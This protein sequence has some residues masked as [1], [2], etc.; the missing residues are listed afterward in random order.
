MQIKTFVT[1]MLIFQICLYLW[2]IVAVSA[3]CLPK[4]GFG[5][6][7]SDTPVRVDGQYSLKSNM[8]EC[9]THC[10]DRVTLIAS[11]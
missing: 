6:S 4:Y 10:D 9:Q 8:S 3:K 5:L 7:Q 2:N 1:K 11:I